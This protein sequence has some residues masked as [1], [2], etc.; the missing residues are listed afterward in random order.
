MSLTR[1]ILDSELYI[2]P[3]Y[4]IYV[5]TNSDLKIA[6][7]IEIWHATSEKVPTYCTSLTVQ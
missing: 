7:S 2:P 3:S 6:N 5:H 1:S 4:L